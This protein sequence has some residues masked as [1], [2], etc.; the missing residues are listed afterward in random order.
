M[1]QNSQN[2]V[3][4]YNSGSDWPTQILMLLLSSLDK[5][6][7]IIFQKGVDNF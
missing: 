1:D 2:I 5:I 4:I 6:H 3:W 7:Y